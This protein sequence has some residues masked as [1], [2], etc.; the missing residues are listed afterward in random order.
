M[1]LYLA[2]GATAIGIGA[3][4]FFTLGLIVPMP[5]VESL[6]PVL[7][8]SSFLLMF[9]GGWISIVLSVR[10]TDQPGGPVY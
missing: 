6:G 3:A 9:A 4:M 2:F 5:M 10:N 1:C 8:I 7:A